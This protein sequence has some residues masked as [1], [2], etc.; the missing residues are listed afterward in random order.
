MTKN[1][2]IRT[3]GCWF[4]RFAR[5]TALFILAMFLFTAYARVSDVHSF[6]HVEAQYMA[7]YSNM[8]FKV[9]A[10]LLLIAAWLSRRHFSLQPFVMAI[11]LISLM[12]MKYLLSDKMLALPQA[13]IPLSYLIFDLAMLG[14]VWWMIASMRPGIALPDK[15]NNQ[16]RW[17]AWLSLLI[18]ILQIVLGVS[19]NSFHAGLICTDLPYCH[20]QLF[21]SLDWLGVFS[22]QNMNEHDIQM[23]VHMLHRIGAVIGLLFLGLFTFSLL[24]N[25][26]LYEFGFMFFLFLAAEFM[27]G[28]FNILWGRPLWVVFS[29]HLAAILMMVMTISFLVRLY[30]K[31][32]LYW[33]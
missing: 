30:R 16:F 26:R 9:I 32:E 6:F 10:I 19:V 11:G 24:R 23:I 3:E 1:M 27:L 17:M 15:I 13:F 25:P 4:T 7:Y 14:L 20:G 12:V 33:K 31:P 18:I 2:F 21:P 28:L 22:L 5:F 29:H 8:I